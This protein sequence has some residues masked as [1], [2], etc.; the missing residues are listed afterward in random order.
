MTQITKRYIK[1]YITL[2]EILVVITLIALITGVLA[3][4]YYGS[5]EKGRAFKTQAGMERVETIL[6]LKAAED[7]KILDNISNGWE[8]VIEESPFVKDKKQLINDGWGSKYNV[9]LDDSGAIKVTSEKYNEYL[10]RQG[11]GG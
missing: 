8:K 9:G 10:K 5:L 6:N 11:Q 4:N 1:R 2:M 3:Y 7:P